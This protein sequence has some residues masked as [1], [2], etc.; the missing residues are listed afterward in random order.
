MQLLCQRGE[1][2]PVPLPWPWPW[3]AIELCPCL[4]HWLLSLPGVSGVPGL[5]PS[6]QELGSQ[7]C[8]APCCPLLCPLLPG[9]PGSLGDMA[10]AWQGEVGTPL[11][12][13]LSSQQGTGTLATAYPN[14][15][16]PW[17]RL[18]P[19]DHAQ[20]SGQAGVRG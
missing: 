4:S 6:A 14:P 3:P 17:P 18:P 5:S 16:L 12:T 15:A 20:T 2:L 9:S 8:P 1:P 7:E 19:P 13:G 11:D 10:S